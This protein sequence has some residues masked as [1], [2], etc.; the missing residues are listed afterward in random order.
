MKLILAIINNDDSDAVTSG[1]TRENFFVTKLSTTGGFLLA[2]N[3]TLLVG[4]NDDEVERVKEIIKKFSKARI[5]PADSP[6]RDV[7]DKGLPFDIHVGG[8]TVFVL[9]VDSKDKF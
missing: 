7:L 4:S 8:A 9:N 3:T 6:E 1:L 2:G 5:S